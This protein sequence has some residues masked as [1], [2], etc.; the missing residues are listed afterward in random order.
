[1]AS[2]RFV[3]KAWLSP[4]AVEESS[5]FEL[6]W[7][8]DGTRIQS[9]WLTSTSNTYLKMQVFRKIGQ[10]SFYVN[11]G[12]N[13]LSCPAEIIN[14]QELLA[15]EG[16]PIQRFEVEWVGFNDWEWDRVK[17]GIYVLGG[18]EGTVQ[19]SETI[20]FLNPQR[21]KSIPQKEVLV[22]VVGADFANVKT[23]LSQIVSGNTDNLQ[24]PFQ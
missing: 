4:K 16:V 19:K 9:G 5:A 23:L 11:V 14:S 3:W 1:M 12:G 17:T 22:N 21:T 15:E 8:Q 13:S 7:N 20:L 6:N 18:T 24:T 2:Y 10:V